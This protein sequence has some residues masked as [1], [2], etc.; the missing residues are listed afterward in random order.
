LFTGAKLKLIFHSH[1]TQSHFSQKISKTI[2]LFSA[3]GQAALTLSPIP[4]IDKKGAPGRVAGA[5]SFHLQSA[6]I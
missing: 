2:A 1:N 6:V 5:P 3:R 4:P